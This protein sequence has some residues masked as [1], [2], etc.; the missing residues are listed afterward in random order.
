MGNCSSFWSGERTSSVNDSGGPPEPPRHHHRKDY[1]MSNPNSHDLL[2]QDELAELDALED[3]LV[4][5]VFTGIGKRRSRDSSPD[6]SRRCRSATTTTRTGRS[7][8]R[9]RR[10]AP[11]TGCRRS[12]KGQPDS[13]SCSRSRDQASRS[14]SAIGVSGSARKR[15]DVQGVRRDRR[16][17]TRAGRWQ[18][19]RAQRRLGH[20]VPAGGGLK[21]L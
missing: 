21:R 20:P 3:R 4:E 16:R 6:L 14:S 15:E 17:R 9:S 8:R 1:A 18:H 5:S 2:S 7:R 13:R 10:C 19:G 11:R 12:G